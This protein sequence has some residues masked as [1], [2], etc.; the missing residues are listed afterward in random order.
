MK[1]FNDNLLHSIADF[2][3]DFQT[4]YGKSPT[5]REIMH[6]FE[7]S[8]LSIVTR[9]VNKL[10][11]LNM[12][13]KTNLGKIDISEKLKIGQSISAPLIGSVACGQPILAIQNIEENYQLPTSL[14]GNQKLYGL[15]AK[16]N[17]MTGA[18]IFDGDIVFFLPCNSANNGDIVVALIDDCAT[19]KRLEIKEKY[20]ILHPE[21]PSYQ[22]IITKNLIIQGIVKHVVHSF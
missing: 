16:G 14:F 20:A 18:G 9:Y 12:I 6:R 8:S 22:P 10:Q 21:N 3:K 4:N 5:S 7:L 11:K 17:S 15:R 1:T 2:V 19:I 13:Q